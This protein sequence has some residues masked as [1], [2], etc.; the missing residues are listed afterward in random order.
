[1]RVRNRRPGVTLWCTRSCTVII[2]ESAIVLIYV[3]C[4]R[5]N[6][7]LVCILYIAAIHRHVCY[8]LNALFICTII[9]QFYHFVTRPFTTSFIFNYI[10][11]VIVLSFLYIFPFM[12]RVHSH[13]ETHPH[14]H[15]HT[16]TGLNDPTGFNSAES[17]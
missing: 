11:K 8:Y 2:T 13:T 14:Y 7:L 4:N 5:C 16:I 17:Q 6:Y 15:A 10:F 12:Y 1:M 3:Q 9:I